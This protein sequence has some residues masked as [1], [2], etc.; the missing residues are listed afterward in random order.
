MKDIEDFD[1]EDENGEKWRELGLRQRGAA[2]LT[3]R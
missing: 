2:S 3:R 1:N